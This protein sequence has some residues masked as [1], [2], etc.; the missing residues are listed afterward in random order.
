VGLIVL[1]SLGYL[2][3]WDWTGFNSGTSQITITSTSKGNYTAIILQ[4]SKSLW[5]WLQLLAV[6]AIPVVVGLGAAWYTVQ[7]GKVN[8][9]E[10]TDNQRETALQAYIDKMSEL[11]LAKDK[12]L[13]QSKP[14]DEEQKIARVRTLTILPRLDAKRKR[15]VLQFLH[16]S[17]LIIK[18]KSIIALDGADIGKSDLRWIH[19]ENDT[20]AG[21][22]VGK[23][24]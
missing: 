19:L 3:K 10:T 8:D 7:Q 24:I 17:G 2:F 12:P 4:P 9:R 11:L 15:S 21:A 1:I 22:L 23:P 18:D 5:D 16:E 20:L 14:E 13:R 6:L